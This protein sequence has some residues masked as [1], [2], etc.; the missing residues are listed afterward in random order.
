MGYPPFIADSASLLLR[1]PGYA[2]GWQDLI[3]LPTPAPGVTFQHVIDGRWSERLY[4]AV[5]RLTTSAVVANR[6]MSLQLLDNNAVRVAA[7]AASGAVAAATAL[8][9]NLC[10]TIPVQ[11]NG[12]TGDTYGYIPDVLAPPGWSWVL[13]VSGIDAGDQVDQVSL[14]VQKFPSDITRIPVAG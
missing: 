10:V 4:A 13:S 7:A 9:A 1:P 3:I 11:A 6:F 2:Q 12:T 14:L 5:F 8:R